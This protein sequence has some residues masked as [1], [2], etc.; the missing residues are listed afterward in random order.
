VAACDEA[1]TPDLLAYFPALSV[2]QKSTTLTSAFV[3]ILT[4]I[5]AI[6]YLF[7]GACVEFVCVCALLVYMSL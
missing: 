6:V 1:V 5:Q 7:V 3:E 4:N 2:Q